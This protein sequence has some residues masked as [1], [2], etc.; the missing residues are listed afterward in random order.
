M[1]HGPDSIG[2]ANRHHALGALVNRFRGMSTSQFTLSYDGSLLANGQ[3]DVRELAPALLAAGELLTA[4][5]REANEN[6]VELSVKVQAGFERGSFEIL[7]IASQTPLNQLTGLLTGENIVTA[8][9]LSMLIFG[10]RGLLD[11][12]KFL[13]R[14]KPDEVERLGN[15][16]VKVSLKDS[17]IVISGNVFNFYQSPAMR[18]AVAPL[19]K[20]LETEGIDVLRAIAEH[21]VLLELRKDDV[22]SLAEVDMDEKIV[23]D[24][25]RQVVLQIVSLSFREENKW[26]LWD[27]SSANLYSMLDADF[28]S[29][30]NKHVHTFGKDDTLVCIVRELVKLTR[31][32]ELKTELSVIKVLEHR[33]APQQ[34]R[35]FPPS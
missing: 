10:G 28:F 14:R 32:G 19:A 15:G 22:A 27:G 7:L 25:E 5:N 35:M 2:P 21:Q 8:S 3:M 29:S 34:T 20:P 17:S 18:R 6:R 30:I 24:T 31:T 23:S 26:R 16:D 12:L 33:R 4:A 1:L 13:K 11:F 9:A